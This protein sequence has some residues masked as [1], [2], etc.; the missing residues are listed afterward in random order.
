MSNYFLDKEGLIDIPH[1]EC[2]NPVNEYFKPMKLYSQSDVKARAIEK[3]GLEMLYQKQA[4]HERIRQWQAHSERITASA[5]YNMYRGRHASDLHGLD[6]IERPN[7]V[8]SHFSP[9]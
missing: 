8:N 2:P 5:A 4:E 7:P 9:M 3:F 6:C 1:E